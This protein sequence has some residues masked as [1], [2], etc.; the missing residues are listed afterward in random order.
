M[1]NS[2]K[3]SVLLDYESQQDR[4]RPTSHEE[5]AAVAGTPV[6]GKVIIEAKKA[7]KCKELGGS[8]VYLTIQ[9]KE[10]T[11]IK[12]GKRWFHAERNI[13]NMGSL[14]KEFEGRKLEP[15]VYSCPFQC[16]LPDYLPERM[17]QQSGSSAEVKYKIKVNLGNQRIERPFSVTTKPVDDVRVP[18]FCEPK[19]MSI[20]ALG[21]RVVGHVTFGVSIKDTTVGRGDV[22]EVAVACKNFSSVDLKLEL[23]VVEIVDFE[24][25]PAGQS[26]SHSVKN[27]LFS[28]E[29]PDM[30][31]LSKSIA[32]VKD[33]RQST[34]LHQENY[35]EI[36]NELLEHRNGVEIM[37]PKHARTSY[38]G[39]LIQVSHYVKVKLMSQKMV[40]NVE[41]KVPLFIGNPPYRGATTATLVDDFREDPQ[42]LSIRASTLLPSAPEGSI[43]DDVVPVAPAVLMDAEESDIL[44]PTADAYVI[45]GE[46][47]VSPYGQSIEDMDLLAPPPPIS[48]TT[49]TLDNL[50]AEMLTSVHD[51]DIIASKLQI[52]EWRM[53]VLERLTPTQFGMILAHVHNDLDQTREAALLAN[54]QHNFHCEYC[55]Q[56]LRNMN[57][58]NRPAMVEALKPHLKDFLWAQN[59]IWDELTQ[60]ERVVVEGRC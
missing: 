24:A 9:A 52:A 39:T 7:V 47:V 51:Y 41:L 18:C 57:D 6:T 60:W 58:W 13:L 28:R 43:Y 5:W 33:L 12:R 8:R 46:A 25:H 27:T 11:A 17:I 30:P 35:R 20:K 56:A 55:V 1:G 40:D 37:V 4:P 22:L 50:L 32:P 49:P 14:L 54:H 31:N 10:K 29:Y 38:K 53:N 23:K 34:T 45:G 26:V 59:K 16:D 36:Y 3:I 21:V 19:T 44:V 48:A 15:G 2:V 42:S